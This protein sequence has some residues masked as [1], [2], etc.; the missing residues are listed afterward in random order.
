[1]PSDR[2]TDLTGTL[3]AVLIAPQG[4]EEAEFTEPKKALES[5][6]AI[7]VVVSL[8]GGE[9]QTR[10]HDLEPGGG[11]PVDRTLDDVTPD[12]VAAVVIPGGTVGADR[13]RADEAVVRFVRGVA[14]QGKPVA[15]I[16]HGPSTLIEAGL[17]S[18]RRLTSFPSL[19]T[20]LRNAGA[21]WVD[22]EVVVDGGVITSRNP[23]D[24][25]AF[26]SALLDA[27]AG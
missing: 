25:D 11:Y 14:D 17:A 3:V 13:L 4:T 21:Q 7:P 16:C 24:L 8:S 15:A 20:D 18:G 10:N 27:L 6:G 12:D 2:T 9:A 19:Q 23:G 22:E 5:A 26:C 1:M